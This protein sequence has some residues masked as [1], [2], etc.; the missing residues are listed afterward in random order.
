[1]LVH[2]INNKMSSYKFHNYYDDNIN[3]PSYTCTSDIPYN[4]MNKSIYVDKR[5]K[6]Y[7][8]R[9]KSREK[10]KRKHKRNLN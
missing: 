7:L 8:K 10:T 5:E 4:K 3:T 1:M 9:Y 6:S 2:S